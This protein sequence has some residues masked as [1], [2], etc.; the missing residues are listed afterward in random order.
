MW[1]IARILAFSLRELGKG[2]GFEEKT[3][4]DLGFKS[5]TL[6][7]VLGKPMKLLISSLFLSLG[8]KVSTSFSVLS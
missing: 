8:L 2:Q 3:S 4:S 5:F 1:A 6:V 7:A